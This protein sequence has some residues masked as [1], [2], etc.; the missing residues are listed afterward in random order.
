MVYSRRFAR[1]RVVLVFCLLASLVEVALLGL[2]LKNSPSFYARV[3]WLQQRVADQANHAFVLSALNVLAAAAYGYAAFISNKLPQHGFLVGL[4]ALLAHD[5]ADL[6]VRRAAW[7][8][9]AWTAVHQP[10]TWLAGAAVITKLLL[11]VV[12]FD[13]LLVSNR[14]R[15]AQRN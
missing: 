1:G 12:L 5:A 4:V 14:G 15:P 3:P 9:V 8:A 6:L 10:A 7:Q 13:C 11:W 2:L